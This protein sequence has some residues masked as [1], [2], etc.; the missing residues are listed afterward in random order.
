MKERSL[1]HLALFS[2]G[3]RTNQRTDEGEKSTTPN[4]THPIYIVLI[5]MPILDWDNV[6]PSRCWIVTATPERLM[7]D[8][9]SQWNTACWKEMLRWNALELLDKTEMALYTNAGLLQTSALDCCRHRN[10]LLFLHWQTREHLT[11]AAACQ[12]EEASLLP[13]RVMSLIHELFQL[14]GWGGPLEP[15]V[16]RHV[17]QMHWLPRDTAETDGAKQGEGWRIQP[18]YYLRVTS[19]C[20]LR[21]FIHFSPNSRWSLAGRSSSSIWNI[22]CCIWKGQVET[23]APSG[24]NRTALL[25]HN[26]SHMALLTHNFSC[27]AM[28]THNFTRTALLTHNLSR[29]AMM[30]H[31][32]NRMA[33]LT[34]NF[35]HTAM[36]THNF[37]CTA[38][39]MH[40]FSCMALLAQF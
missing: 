7:L 31:N 10:A 19:P 16:V 26:F 36:L 12:H 18:Y 2:M 32:F 24:F 6:M 40:N 8:W 13:S 39:L 1:L 27:M 17:P 15:C 4:C 23:D 34:H 30:M 29:M 20:D 28:L 22:A 21:P 35:S 37:S 11:V 5:V 38:V 25:T 3:S 14:Y 9:E 33:L